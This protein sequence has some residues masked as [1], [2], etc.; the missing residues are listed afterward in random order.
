MNT[1]T[2]LPVLQVILTTANIGVLAYAF[3]RF[4]NKPHD[5]LEARVSALEIKQKDI[6]LAL[7]QGNDRFREQNAMN[8]AIQKSLLALIEFE[9]QYCTV[10]GKAISKDLERARDELHNYLARKTYA[11]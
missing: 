8:E 4:L 7:H 11:D 2:I 1:Q 5:T 6:E 10:E 9:I 3:L